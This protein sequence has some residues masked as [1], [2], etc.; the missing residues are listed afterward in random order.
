MSQAN[1]GVGVVSLID[2]DVTPDISYPVGY[3]KDVSVEF[4][5]S[6]KELIA[7]ST[8]PEDIAVT[9]GKITGKFKFARINGELFK[10]VNSGATSAAGSIM[11]AI[12]EAATI[13]ATPFAVTVT[14]AADYRDDLGVIDASTGTLMARVTGTPT[15]GQYSLVEATGIY[16]F[17]A[18]DTGK[19]LLISYSYDVTT[20]KTISYSNQ[21]MGTATYYEL[22]AFNSYRAKPLG[23]RFYACIIP[24][25]SFALKNEDFTDLDMDFACSKRLTDDKVFEIYTGE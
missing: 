21:L 3:I 13:P 5:K 18:A 11:P 2:R 19:A 14:H 23:F 15:T 8:F 22:V 25:L 6:T 1:F 10:S 9:G 24:K 16:T 20:G 17:A 12:R 7:E 4:S